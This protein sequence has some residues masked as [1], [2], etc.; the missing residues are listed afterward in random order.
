MRTTEQQMNM[1]H[2]QKQSMQK[3]TTTNRFLKTNFSELL[4]LIAELLFKDLSSFQQCC[5][6]V[7][8]TW[9]TVRS[10][11]WYW[12]HIT[13]NLHYASR[14]KNVLSNNT[15]RRKRKTKNHI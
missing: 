10:V 13:I 11:S 1:L 3:Y 4:N 7:T 5:V 8:M 15:P 14:D 9:L 2:D 6:H 12:N